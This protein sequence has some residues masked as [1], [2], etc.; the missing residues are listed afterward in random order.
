MYCVNSFIMYVSHIIMVYINLYSSV[1]QVEGEKKKGAFFFFE[2]SL[3]LVAW[4]LVAPSRLSLVA[5]SRAYSLG[6]LI[7]VASSVAKDWL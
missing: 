5:M 7:A 6:L 4:V 2:Y 1:C 3:F